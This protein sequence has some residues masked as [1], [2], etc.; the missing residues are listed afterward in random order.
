MSDTTK[1]YDLNSDVAQH[2]IAYGGLSAVWQKFIETMN[3][4]RSIGLLPQQNLQLGNFADEMKSLGEEIFEIKVT[5]KICS[6][7]RVADVYRVDRATLPSE[8]EVKAVLSVLAVRANSFLDRS[9]DLLSNLNKSYFSFNISGNPLIDNILHLNFPYASSNITLSHVSSNRSYSNDQPYGTHIDTQRTHTFKSGHSGLIDERV[10]FSSIM[11]F[12]Q[13]D[14]SNSDIVG[15]RTEYCVDLH[16]QTQHTTR[17]RSG[18]PS[19]SF[20]AVRRPKITSFRYISIDQVKA[21]NKIGSGGFGTVFEGKYGLRDVA[22]K[23]F[24]QTDGQQQG[25]VLHTIPQE[26]MVE[27]EFLQQF[28]HHN[29]VQFYGVLIDNPQTLEPKA[30]VMELGKNGSLYQYLHTM[31]NILLWPLR[32]R[33]SKDLAAGLAYLHENRVIHQDIKSLNVVLDET[34]VA[35]W[36]DFGMANLKANTGSF[37]TSSTRTQV[38]GTT[39]WLAPERLDPNISPSFE[40]DIWALGMVFMELVTRRIPYASTTDDAII[41]NWIKSGTIETVPE[42]GHPHFAGIIKSC[43]KKERNLR[44]SAKSILESL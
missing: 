32:L 31:T 10:V 12:N 20:P 21:G 44:P 5:E 26:S 28:N 35:K 33:I 36:C 29:I 34:L 17:K 6:L 40:S 1:K 7:F 19:A 37:R 3:E 9:R 8:T 30:L 22:I 14:S 4:I 38:F 16:Q 42:D 24:G 15:L 13:L 27:V 41:R 25:T 18:D 2:W 11:S 43:L 23:Y 39:R